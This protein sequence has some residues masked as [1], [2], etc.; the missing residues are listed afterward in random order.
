MTVS[1]GQVDDVSGAH[2][3]NA[4]ADGE[5]HLALQERDDHGARGGVF[6]Q[7]LTGVE[8]EDDG[9]QDVIVDDDS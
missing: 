3:F 6:G 4:L 7:E 1:G 2:P 9:A 8:G 5:V